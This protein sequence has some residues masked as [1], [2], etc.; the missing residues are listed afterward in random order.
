MTHKQWTYLDIQGISKLLLKNLRDLLEP[1]VSKF[2]RLYS[3]HRIYPNSTWYQ[4][5]Q[6]E[7]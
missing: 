6:Q 2:N 3:Q 7:L 4:L 1:N 5:R